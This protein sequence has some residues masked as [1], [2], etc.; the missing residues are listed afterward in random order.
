M[1]YQPKPSY[2]A[3]CLFI[4]NSPIYRR[5]VSELLHMGVEFTEASSFAEAQKI[6]EQG[7]H[8]FDFILVDWEM[9]DAHG[10][11]SLQSLRQKVKKPIIL[12]AGRELSEREFSEAMGSG[13]VTCL[14][15]REI[16][17]RCEGSTLPVSEEQTYQMEPSLVC[18][19][20]D[21]VSP[22]AHKDLQEGLER[23]EATISKLKP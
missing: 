9:V 12:L 6:L 7:H 13:V 3:H 23:L 11:D 8:F 22:S 4:E 2:K 1:Q 21:A 16:Q 5:W 14:Q 10:I 15:K 20:L 17:R 19:V 18:T